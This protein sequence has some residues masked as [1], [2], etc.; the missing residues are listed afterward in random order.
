MNIV[1]VEECEQ[2][3]SIS[4]TRKQTNDSQ[5]DF[6]PKTFFGNKLFGNLGLSLKTL[7]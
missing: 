3:H 6:K 4:L 7:L 5:A 1:Q 2:Q